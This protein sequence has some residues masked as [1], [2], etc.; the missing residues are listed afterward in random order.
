MIITHS[1]AGMNYEIIHSPLLDTGEYNCLKNKRMNILYVSTQIF[2]SF[3]QR[4]WN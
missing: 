3:I 2:N 4:L 1:I